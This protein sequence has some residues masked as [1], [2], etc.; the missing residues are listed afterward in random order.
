MTTLKHK[1]PAAGPTLSFGVGLAAAFCVLLAFGVPA[2]LANQASVFQGSFGFSCVK[3]TAG[4]TTPDPYPLDPDPWSAAV[5]DTTG[6][7]YVTDAANHRVEEFTSKGK[8]VLMFGKAVNKTKAGG[9]TSEAN[10]CS[11]EEVELM[12]VEC[13]AGV[14]SP[15]PGG[16]ES[17]PAME[18]F[19]AVDNSTG[20]SSGDV[21]V[22]D[23]F[24][25][26]VGNR[27]SKFDAAGGLISGWGKA[28]EMDGAG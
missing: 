15:E 28:G 20:L 10:V 24:E 19:V 9:F 25:D 1:K 17:S 26:G 23:Y 18:M 2:A 22:G 27:V 16:F 11:E 3:G 6:N 5:N 21:Y 12:S 13:Q 4:C 8:F 7:V 14:A